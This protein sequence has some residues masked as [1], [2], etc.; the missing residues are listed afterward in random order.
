MQA[1]ATYQPCFPAPCSHWFLNFL[2]CTEHRSIREQ[3]AQKQQHGTVCHCSCGI[4][5]K[6]AVTGVN[7]FASLNFKEFLC[8]MVTKCSGI[9]YAT[10]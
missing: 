10:S 6:F 4:V 8:V 7:H 5:V 2:K 9:I 3:S 1:P